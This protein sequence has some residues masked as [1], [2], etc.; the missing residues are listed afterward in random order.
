VHH[1]KIVE[2]MTAP[3]QFLPRQ[4]SISVAVKP[5]IADSMADNLRGR[6]G[7]L[8]ALFTATNWVL[9]D[10]LGG[11]DFDTQRLAFHNVWHV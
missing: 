7:P 1:S 3:G 5:P 4:H 8:A 6:E 2:W 10:D 11:A 9:F